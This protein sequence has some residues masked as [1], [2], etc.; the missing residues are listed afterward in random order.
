MGREQITFKGQMKKGVNQSKKGLFRFLYSRTLVIAA[1][2][3]LQFFIL[4]SIF[5]VLQNS[6]KF[7]YAAMSV[8]SMIL[9]IIIVNNKENPLYQMSWVIP[10]LILP[11][12]G[13]LFY[14]FMQIQTDTKRLAK[15]HERV[16][17]HTRKYLLQDKEVMKR[18]EIEN[19]RVA[20]TAK[21]VSNYGGY[22]MYGA[23]EVSYFPSG[24]AMFPAL[25]REIKKAKR[26]IFLEYFIVEEGIMWNTILEELEKKVKEGVE[27]RL[28][29]DGLCGLIQL[30]HHYQEKMRKKGIK[31][32]IYAPIRPAIATY[33]N[34]RDHRKIVSIDGICGFTGGVNLADEY[35]NKKERFGYWKDTAVMVKGSAV[36]SFTLMFLQLWNVTERVEDNYESY[37]VKDVIPTKLSKT[38]GYVMPYADSPYDDENVGEQVYFDLINQATRYLYIMTPYLILDH[39]MMS[40]LTHAAKRGVKVKLIMPHI[41]DKKYAFWLAHTYYEELLRAKVKIYEFTP[42]F[43]HAKVFVADGKKAVVGSINLDFRSFYLHYESGVYVFSHPVIKE[44]ESDCRETIEISEE[45]T[46]RK[47]KKF[48]IGQKIAGRILRLVAPLM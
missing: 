1:L 5:F 29:Y 22:P 27:V 4:F 19:M 16:L 26:Y 14:L 13:G 38:G 36:N 7:F 17:N 47:C 40:A 18:L 35:I 24:E 34:N 11:V 30:P 46:L 31:C 37:L 23:N 2:L 41:P 44:I 20:S 6:F 43:V 25:L 15:R 10:I 39:E 9:V 45:I 32:K 33:Q 3:L 21:Y 12:F 48:P 8:L 42:G 28:M